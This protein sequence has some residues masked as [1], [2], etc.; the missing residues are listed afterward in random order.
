MKKQY[1]SLF[2]AASMS[3]LA[4]TGT[5]FAAAPF[6]EVGNSDALHEALLDKKVAIRLTGDLVLE[7]PITVEWPLVLD[8]NGHTILAASEL[9]AD[10]VRETAVIN[11]TGA[12]VSV[13]RLT[14]D[15][16]SPD[17]PYGLAGRN[18]ADLVLSE[19]TLR[20]TGTG[21]L[22]TGE[23]GVS[24][25]ISDVDAAGI[26]HGIVASGICGSITGRASDLTLDIGAG[27]DL[28]C[29]GVDTGIFRLRLDAVSG[30]APSCV[31]P[32]CL[33]DCYTETIEDG[34]LLR[35]YSTRR[36]EE[37]EDVLS[38]AE[39]E[40]AQAVSESADTV[41][42]T[43]SLMRTAEQGDEQSAADLL[44]RTQ[45]IEYGGQEITGPVVA[46]DG[47]RMGTLPWQLVDA[48]SGSRL[49]LQIQY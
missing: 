27:T 40:R 34:K 36:S 1:L 25:K 29:S 35:S 30:A 42:Q 22:L 13:S 4:L 17:L 19:L 9:M 33:E 15:N 2:L 21:L 41:K 39:R 23:G 7:R 45:T 28:D 20:G 32:S 43:L 11:I 3:V 47:D 26:E 49:L 37:D 5:A 44:R 24:M 31:L 48:V 46:L 16:Q 10:N 12:K 6:C 14:V 18:S 38:E 8:G